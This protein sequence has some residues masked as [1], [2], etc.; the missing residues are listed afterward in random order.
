MSLMA[1]FFISY[2]A[3]DNRWAS[4]IAF[5]L[6]EERYTTVLQEWDFRPGTN[7][8][9]AMQKAAKEADRTI[10]VLS[11]AYLDSGFAGSEWAAAFS[12]DPMGIEKKLVPVV[13]QM[14]DPGGILGPIVHI[15]LIGKSEA[16]ARQE[17]IKGLKGE[18]AK[19]KKRRSF[20]G[21]QRTPSF[22]GDAPQS[23]KP[24]KPTP[25][26]PKVRRVLNPLNRCT[27]RKWHKYCR[28]P[29]VEGEIHY[30]FREISY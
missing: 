4:W 22:P 23:V 18:R 16:E 25:Y 3:A 8:A 30:A 26:M 29:S 28:H 2:T 11:P 17:L 24:A 7:F 5:V 10:M 12:K 15:N 13:V 14:C 27:L 1:D 21:E 6:E 20:P 19:P 9:L